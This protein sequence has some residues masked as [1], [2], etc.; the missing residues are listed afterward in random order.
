MEP[1]MTYT[2]SIDVAA[3]VQVYDVFHAALVKHT[4]GRVDGL[5]THIAW[6]TESGFRM[7]EVWTSKEARDR[8]GQEV[9]PQVWAELTAGSAGPVGDLPEERVQELDTRGL[10]IPSADLAV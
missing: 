7:I 2:V 10:I 9:M 6:P 1:T 4:G 3:P 8:V 5:L